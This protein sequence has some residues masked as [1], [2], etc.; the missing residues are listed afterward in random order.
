MSGHFPF[1][2]CC[3][4][5][6][7][8]SMAHGT[9]F[10]SLS[11]LHCCRQ[12]LLVSVLVMSKVVPKEWH[13][14]DL[15]EGIQNFLL[16]VEMLFFAIA[17]YFVFSHKPFIDPAAAEVPC[18]A[19]CCRML[20]VRDVAGDVKEHFV[21]PI[22]RPRFRSGGR[23]TIGVAGGVSGEGEGSEVGSSEEA[24][25]LRKGTSPPTRVSGRPRHDDEGS[26]YG[27]EPLGGMVRPLLEASKGG[28]TDLS[29]DMLSLGDLDNRRDGYGRRAELIAAACRKEEEE[30]EGGSSSQ[31]SS[32]GDSPLSSNSSH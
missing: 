19:T 2:N 9:Y 1:T 10:S 29:F 26:G 17:H 16:V 14:R 20:D 15:Q 23:S 21:D 31:H 32:R 8:Q 18:I 25:L 4:Y 22:P 5:I 28:V 3:S 30:E 13:E 7:M 11:C 27:S 12:N 24:P 6:D